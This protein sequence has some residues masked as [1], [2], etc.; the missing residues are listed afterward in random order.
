MTHNI[1]KSIWDDQNIVDVL[2]GGG[3]VVMPTDTIY[4]MVTKA[5]DSVSV[6]R[7]YQIRKRAPEKPCIVL[8]GDIQ[9][10]QNFSIH[11]SDEQKT[12]LQEY[13]N[14]DQ[15]STEQKRPTS[16]IFDCSEERFAY[17]H[18]GTQSLAFR[19]PAQSELRELLLQTGPLIAPSANTEKFPAS[20]NIDDAKSYFGDD[21]DLYI[22]GGPIVSQAS[23]VIKLHKDGSI[24]ILRE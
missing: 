11:L 22:D 20:E 13:W 23:Q 1:Q 16:I 24:N 12:K 10:L 15:N 9:E 6:E 2:K 14:V 8:I 17:L 19:L 18:R 5:L 21:V 4:G 3:V 7:I